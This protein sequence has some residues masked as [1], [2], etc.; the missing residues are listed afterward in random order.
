M[1]WS[2]ACIVLLHKWKGVKCES[3]NSRGISLLS[4]IGKQYGSV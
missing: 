4:V 2:G 3:S 1:D